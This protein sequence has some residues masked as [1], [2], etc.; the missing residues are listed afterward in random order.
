MDA[1]VVGGMLPEE[2]HTHVHK[3]H[4]VQSAASV[5][6]ITGGMGSH[7]GELVE[8]LYAGVV[9]AGAHLVHVG[10]M[11]AE[12][13][14]QLFPQAV[15]SHEGLAAA[16]FFTGTAIEYHSAAASAL[17]Q[18]I[19][20]RRSGSQRTGPQ[21]IMAAAVAAAS[22]HQWLRLRTASPLAQARQGIILPKD[23]YHRAAAAVAAAEG[24]IYA[25]EL[26]S[27]LKAQLPQ[28]P[29]V[30]L[31]CRKFLQGQLRLFPYAVRHIAEK[32]RL[33]IY[34][35]FCRLFFFRHYNTLDKK[36]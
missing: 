17:F 19:L 2:L 15:P 7:T 13:S 20:H 5:I 1:A 35:F 3:L 12:G 27:N 33:C 11:P 16:T 21:Q 30:D 10:G 28:G 25:A 32:F 26:F 9:G 24:G 34:K 6:G 4:G 23:A 18:V 31:R 36:S 22:G 14:V 29:A 8:Y